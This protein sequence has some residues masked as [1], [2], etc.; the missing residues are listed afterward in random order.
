M[1]PF[2]NRTCDDKYIISILF[3]NYREVF[4][5]HNRP[6]FQPLCPFGVI[7]LQQNFF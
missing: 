2:E 7:N 6:L 1:A 5:F 3:N 4:S